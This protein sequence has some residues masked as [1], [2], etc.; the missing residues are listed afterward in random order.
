MIVPG[1]AASIHEAARLLATGDIVAFPTETVY[2]LGADAANADAVAK[3]FAAKDRP[4]FNPLISHAADIGLL[5]TEVLFDDR[6][7][8]L[9]AHFWPG[10]LTLVLNKH[11]LARGARITNA[12]L[13]SISVRIPAHPVALVM[14]EEFARIG[15]GLVAAPSANRSNMLSP[16]TAQ[17]VAES[18]GR[19]VPF[20]LDGGRTCIGVESTIIDLTGEIARVLRPGGL[21][22]ER[23][24][25]LIGPC[26]RVAPGDKPIAPGMLARHYAP[27]KPMRLNATHATDDEAFLLFGPATANLGGR[28]RLNLSESGDTVEAAANLFDHLHRLEL[29]DVAAIAVMPIPDI[30]LGVAINDRL[31]RGA[32][33]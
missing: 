6:A 3:I 17:H 16:T 27:K 24:E 9:A 15:S 23:I 21:A 25:A 8:L 20:I 4:H 7:E 33:P 14:L 28:L 22:L 11:P 29:T 32:T 10:P 30:G 13:P 19:R 5:R 2:A 18:L 31:R 1:E 12:G 26:A